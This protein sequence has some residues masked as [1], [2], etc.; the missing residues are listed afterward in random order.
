M[1]LRLVLKCA[2][3]CG[4]SLDQ[5]VV[6]RKVGMLFVA[7]LLKNI[8]RHRVIDVFSQQCLQLVVVRCTLPSAEGYV[9]SQISPPEWHSNPGE[10]PG[11]IAAVLRSAARRRDVARE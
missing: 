5:H 1:A 10:I 2:L 4:L 3:Q 11:Q 6:L 9:P 8:P 7:Q